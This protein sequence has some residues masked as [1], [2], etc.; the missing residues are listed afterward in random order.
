MTGRRHVHIQTGQYSACMFLGA[1]CGCT[2]SQQI[3]EIYRLTG[4]PSFP[5][6]LTQVDGNNLLSWLLEEITPNPLK[7]S[8]ERKQVRTLHVTTLQYQ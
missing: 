5:Y 6:L 2:Y 4:I 8:L 1:P 3:T 7:L